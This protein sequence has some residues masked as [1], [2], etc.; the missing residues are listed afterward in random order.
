MYPQRQLFVASVER[1]AI[2]NKTNL[3][4]ALLELL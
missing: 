1:V 3:D 2:L 4:I